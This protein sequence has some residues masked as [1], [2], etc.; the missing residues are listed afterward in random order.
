VVTLTS[1]GEQTSIDGTAT[2]K[3]GG[4][5]GVGEGEGAGEGTD[6]EAEDEEEEGAAEGAGTKEESKPSRI[7]GPSRMSSQSR[8]IGGAGQTSVDGPASIADLTAENDRLK[9]E[10]SKSGKEIA[11]LKEKVRQFEAGSSCLPF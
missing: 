9:E 5:E 4:E 10:S 3:A 7:I 6:E 8:N 11:A 1:G 2:L